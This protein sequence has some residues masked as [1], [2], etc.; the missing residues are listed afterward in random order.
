MVL[1]NYRETVY[2]SLANLSSSL[3]LGPP[4]II[5][6]NFLHR[7][8][9]PLFS[10]TL[11]HASLAFPVT[12]GTAPFSLPLADQP[13]RPYCHMTMWLR[14][15]V[16]Q[17]S[18]AIALCSENSNYDGGISLHLQNAGLVAIGPNST[19][20]D[21]LCPISC[22]A[23]SRNCIR[24]F[25]F[26]QLQLF[27]NLEGYPAASVAFFLLSVAVLLLLFFFSEF[28]GLYRYMLTLFY[29]Y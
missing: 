18:S 13:P 28:S 14:Y 3:L 7:V 29:T 11:S 24:D 26:N 9:Y 20:L 10:L 19:A 27:Q 8:S 12:L 1:Q 22:T 25:L 21:A 4:E 15:T 17:K 16:R 6:R 23:V 5:Q 2:S